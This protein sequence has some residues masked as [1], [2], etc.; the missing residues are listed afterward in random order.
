LCQ[1][2]KGKEEEGLSDD[3]FVVYDEDDNEEMELEEADLD[4]YEEDDFV[5]NDD[6]VEE[7]VMEEDGCNMG[8]DISA[9]QDN[10]TKQDSYVGVSCIFQLIYSI[11]CFCKE[12]K[13]K[14]KKITTTSD[15]AANEKLSGTKR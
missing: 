13:A 14:K 9:S 10:I 2:N 4:E 1:K 5:V 7:E 8:E 6:L 3:D 11:I 15:K 12:T